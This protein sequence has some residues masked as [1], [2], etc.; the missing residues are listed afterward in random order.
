M[1]IDWVRTTRIFNLIEK[2]MFCNR[3]LVS[4]SKPD[5]VMCPRCKR[6]YESNTNDRRKTR[7][8]GKKTS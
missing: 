8:Q 6:I 7:Q 4:T 2:C 3:I 5:V 1:P